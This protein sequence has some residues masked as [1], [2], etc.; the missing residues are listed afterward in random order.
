MQTPKFMTNSYWRKTAEGRKRKEIIRKR[1]Y[2]RI[3]DRHYA[4]VFKV[5]PKEIKEK[6]IRRFGPGILSKTFRNVREMQ[7]SHT[8]LLTAAIL[9]TDFE[10]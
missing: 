4:G 7:L 2:Y 10:L 5:G 9:V 6:V 3:S 1:V 8:K